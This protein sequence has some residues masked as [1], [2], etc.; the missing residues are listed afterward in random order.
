M[1]RVSEVYLLALVLPDRIELGSVFLPKPGKHLEKVEKQNRLKEQFVYLH[2][3]GEET[4]HR[5][6]LKKCWLEEYGKR[7]ALSVS[8]RGKGVQ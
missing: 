1:L 3:K 5:E 8:G 7:K 6:K 4:Q 2:F